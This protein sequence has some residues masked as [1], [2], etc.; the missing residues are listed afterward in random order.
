MK[1]NVPTLSTPYI[2]SYLTLHQTTNTP[3]FHHIPTKSKYVA[4]QVEFEQFYQDLLTNLIYTPDNE[5]TLLETK[6]RSTCEK[7]IKIN[8]LCKYKKVIDNLSK[9]KN[10]FRQGK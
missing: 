2:I 6:L 3:L 7:H 9:D 5:L 10:I 4:I 8:V 1:S